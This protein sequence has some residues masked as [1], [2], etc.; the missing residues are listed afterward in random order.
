MI[1]GPIYMTKLS[2]PA[3]VPHSAGDGT[4]ASHRAQVTA[5]ASAHD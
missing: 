2:R 4:P 5:T 3:S 1:A